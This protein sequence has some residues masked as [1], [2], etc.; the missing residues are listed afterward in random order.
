[1][2]ITT[3][4]IKGAKPKEK[5]YRLYDTGG[6][7]M[8]ITPSGGKLW[9]FKYRY[10]GK[11]KLLA[12]GKYPDLSLKEA[13]AKHSEARN[14]L[15]NELDPSAVK[16]EVKQKNQDAASNSFEIVTRE[17]AHKNSKKWTPS[18]SKLV[19][20]RF[21]RD[22]FP[23]LGKTAI[24]NVSAPELLKTLRRI[25][26]RNAL[27]TAHKILQNCGQVFRYAIATGRATSD[28]SAALK[29]ALPPV[30]QRH[31]SS[32][33]DPV[34][35][36]GLLRAIRDYQGSFVTKCALNFAPLVFVRPTE[37]RHAEWQEIDTE[38]AEWRIP[39]NKMKMGAVHIVPLST[40]AIAIL[41][42]LRPLTGNGKY[43]FP[44]VRSASRPMSENTI[45][46]ALRRLG[47]TSKEM[48]GHG[49]RSMASTLLNEQGWHWD[50]I[51]RQL[52][53][54]ERNSVRAAYNY[55]EHMPERIRMMQHWAD[56]LDVLAQG[57]DVVSI[58]KNGA[59]R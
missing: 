24:E 56:Y 7:Y 6:L 20:R 22:V 11:E 2:P 14:Q 49:F 31:H 4:A 10:G 54:S 47:Y 44:S 28:P 34:A 15:A 46:A 3:L 9:R 42:E 32:I 30:K 39:A 1:M 37:L 18:N 38:K 35:I 45:N 53:H 48:T 57:G 23:W 50:A 17:W 26:N 55:A 33:T 29:G 58:N 40:Q 43:L 51:E 59:K 13:R 16:Q 36:G 27:Y 12:I 5:K 21:E 52:A 41:D 25:E 8:E 19:I